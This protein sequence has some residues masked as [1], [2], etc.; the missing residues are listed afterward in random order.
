M[1]QNSTLTV[2][3]AADTL[4]VSEEYLER[5]LA[6]GAIP[7]HG[8]DGVPVVLKS[9][10]ESYA[11]TSLAKRKRALTELAAQAQELGMGY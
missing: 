7:S 2:T 8:T 10:V 1:M 9:D 4:N 5:L 3:E 6:S 11:A